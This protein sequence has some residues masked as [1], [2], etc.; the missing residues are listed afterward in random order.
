MKKGL[1]SGFFWGINTV[2]IGIAL[3]LTP[4]TTT[5]ELIFLAPFISTF[6][7]D[8]FSF[9]WMFIYM[10]GKKQTQGFIKALFSK[11]GR[12]ISLAA[13]VGGPVGMTGYI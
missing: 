6:I 3:S 9:I 13:L 10:T 5:K 12:Y 7:H 11:S 8:F 1:L 4:L 2:I